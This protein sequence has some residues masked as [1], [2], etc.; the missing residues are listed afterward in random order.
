LHKQFP[1]LE[2]T[3]E[4]LIAE[5]DTVAARTSSKGTNLGRFG[6]VLPATGKP[7]ASSQSHWFRV[8]SGKLVEHWAVRDDLSTLLQLGIVQLPACVDAQ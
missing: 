5:G 7:F 3:I 1:D 4:A 6:G 8:A 2:I